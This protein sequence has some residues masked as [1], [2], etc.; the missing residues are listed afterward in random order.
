LHASCA[1]GVF[2]WRT[3]LLVPAC[4]PVSLGELTSYLLRVVG[5][6]PARLHGAAADQLPNLQVERSEDR[7]NPSISAFPLPLALLGCRWG[8]MSGTMYGRRAM[9]RATALSLQWRCVLLLLLL[10]LLCVCCLAAWKPQ[11]T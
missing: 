4:Q 2:G 7:L 1:Y 5:V 8:M 10:L 3:W 9:C 11:R 6:L